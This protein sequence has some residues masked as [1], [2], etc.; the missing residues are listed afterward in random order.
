MPS[1]SRLWRQN[2]TQVH[3]IGYY[4]IFD[5]KIVTFHKA[6]TDIWFVKV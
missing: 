2:A 1:E 6:V 3:N 4:V 5:I